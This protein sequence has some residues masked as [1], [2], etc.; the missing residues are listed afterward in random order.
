MAGG[1]AAGARAPPPTAA[2]RT[3]ADG[4]ERSWLV[5]RAGGRATV[6][7]AGV[8]ATVVGGSTMTDSDGSTTG[9][10]VGGAG[11]AVVGVGGFGLGCGLGLA[12]VV[13]GA[14]VLCVVVSRARGAPRAAGLLDPGPGAAIS[15]AR[16]YCS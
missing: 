2:I 11:L 16:A 8:D 10:V 6:C 3:A 13:V 15:S 9:V 7:G 4:P 1:A 14:A 12:L 5:G